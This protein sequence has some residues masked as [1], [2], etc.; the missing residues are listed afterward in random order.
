MTM[1]SCDDMMYISARGPGTFQIRVPNGKGLRQRRRRMHETLHGTIDQA[2][3][4]RDDLVR[5]RDA[6]TIRGNG[7]EFMRAYLRRWHEGRVHLRYSSAKRE[8]FHVA[9]LIRGLGSLR[10]RELE[11]EHVAAFA[12]EMLA[13]G[14]AAGGPLHP[15]TV[16]NCLA[17]LRKAL[18]DAVRDQLLP[19]NP[20]RWRE[21]SP[22]YEPEE[23]RALE[24]D[25]VELV[26]GAMRH[27]RLELLTELD[28][29]TGMRLG[30]ILGLRLGDFH[31]DQAY[32]HVA[33]QLQAE[34][35]GL[36]WRSPKSKYSVRDLPLS[37]RTVAS[38]RAWIADRGLDHGRDRAGRYLFS[39]PDGRPWGPS[40]VST[41]FSER[42]RGVGLFG[43]SPH[44][45]RHTFITYH[46]LTGTNLKSLIR[47]AGHK[48]G[49]LILT[50]YGHII[51]RLESQHRQPALGLML[52]RYRTDAP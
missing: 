15:K 5:A 25:E 46:L 27:T 4:R 26:L 48:D 37:A 14:S 28:L 22:K 52:Q 31:L 18:N 38:V 20:V 45:M 2:R 42:A 30:E 32:V 49:T 19:Y 17:I 50:T 13:R 3:D 29:D 11:H 33:G 34:E 7:Q 16:R 8:R 51:E 43:V 44:T 24:P 1:L 9:S 35:H 23:A 47:L 40:G 39:Q 36:V 10:L 21:A 6:G 12:R 41:E